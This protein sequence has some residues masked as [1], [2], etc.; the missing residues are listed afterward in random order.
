M[1][2]H[3]NGLH[4]SIHCLMYQYIWLQC[5]DT[6]GPKTLCVLIQWS[7]YRYYK[8]WYR[9][10]EPLFRFYEPLY[11]YMLICIDTFL[12]TMHVLV[13]AWSSI[14]TCSPVS[15]QRLMYRYI[16]I[17]YQYKYGHFKFLARW[18]IVSIHENHVSIHSSKIMKFLISFVPGCLG[19]H[20]LMP[21]LCIYLWYD[22]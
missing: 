7:M 14:D 5:I 19:L 6:F 21:H 15:I 9:Y 20:H 10:Y 2:D 4:V 17:L 12:Y 11:R 16:Y 8:P 13:L 22:P 18:S 3:E 1:P